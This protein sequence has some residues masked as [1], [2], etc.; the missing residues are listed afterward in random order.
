[1]TYDELC[2]KK[3]EAINV[4]DESQKS[5]PI[6]NEPPPLIPT[7]KLNC[8]VCNVSCNSQQ[9]FDNHVAGKKHQTKL[10]LSTVSYSLR[11]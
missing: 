8:N 3:P 6:V 11:F 1:M 5:E 7:K 10:K 2:S 4:N 9:M